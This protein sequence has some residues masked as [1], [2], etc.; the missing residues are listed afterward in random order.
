MVSKLLASKKPELE[1]LKNRISMLIN[2]DELS[3]VTDFDI[4][5]FK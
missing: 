1:R 4:S 3:T 5:M 2:V